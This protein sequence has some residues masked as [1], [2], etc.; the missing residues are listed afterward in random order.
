M[1]VV[2]NMTDSLLMILSHDNE[3]SLSLEKYD[4]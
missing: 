2:D 1:L 3:Y 4:T